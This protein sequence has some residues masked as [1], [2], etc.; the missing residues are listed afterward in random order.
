M[1]FILR[2]TPEMVRTEAM[3]IEQLG[4]VYFVG[5]I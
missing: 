5:Y 1:S 3:S 2:M 4:R